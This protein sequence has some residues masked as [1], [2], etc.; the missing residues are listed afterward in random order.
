MINNRHL[1]G[2]V[3]DAIQTWINTNEI[4]RLID[5]AFTYH[6]VDFLVVPAWSWLSVYS[7]IAGEF[8][9]IPHCSHKSHTHGDPC[10]PYMNIS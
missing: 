7:A 4:L 5:H 2:V 1:G 6:Q 8:L 3:H 10:T 9:Q